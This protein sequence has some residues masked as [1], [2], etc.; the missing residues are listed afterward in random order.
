MMERYPLPVDDQ[1][2]AT[3]RVPPARRRLMDFGARRL[4]LIAG[5]LVCMLVLAGSVWTALS[6]HR[7]GTPPVIEAARGP[8]RVRP[9]NPGGMQLAG[10]NE[11]ILSRDSSNRAGQLAPA[12]EAPAPQVLRARQQAAAAAAAASAAANGAGTGAVPVS[13]PAASAAPGDGAVPP[14][15]AFPPVVAAAPVRPIPNPLA[16]PPAPVTGPANAPAAEAARPSAVIEAARPSAPGRIQAQLAAVGSE[17][18]A[19]S[20]WQRLNKRMPDVLAG[21]QP[22]VLKVDRDGKVMWRLRTGGFADQ[23]Q[24]NAFCNQ[25]KA[26]GANCAVATF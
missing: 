1:P 14:A 18:A 10:Q 6:G 11:D 22:V 19:K 16:S 7:G 21:R 24:A 8:M 20:E 17:Q 4:A 13:V 12:P 9:E 2:E 25:V 23:A 5:F 26:K 15:A 3:Y